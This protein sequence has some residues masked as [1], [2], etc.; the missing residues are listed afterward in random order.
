MRDQKCVFVCGLLVDLKNNEVSW[1]SHEDRALMYSSAHFA[2]LTKSCSFKRERTEFNKR[3]K[4]RNVNCNPL[5]Q[6]VEAQ[7]CSCFDVVSCQWVTSKMKTFAGKSTVPLCEQVFCSN[8]Y[9]QSLWILKASVILG[10]GGQWFWVFEYTKAIRSA[11]FQF[12]ASSQFPL[13]TCIMFKMCGRQICRC[14]EGWP[15]KMGLF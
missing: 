9:F 5:K 11:V 3:K 15:W 7:E 2:L 14:G 12:T 6:V 4:N 13:R 10:G 8:A 1:E